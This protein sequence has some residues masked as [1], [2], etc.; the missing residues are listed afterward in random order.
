MLPA[1]NKDLNKELIDGYTN[2]RKLWTVTPVKGHL[3]SSGS[4]ISITSQPLWELLNPRL[5]IRLTF[6]NCSICNCLPNQNQ[7]HM[8]FNLETIKLEPA[9][10]PSFLINA[11]YD[12]IKQFMSIY[13]T[14]AISQIKKVTELD[15]LIGTLR[16]EVQQS[17]QAYKAEALL[18]K[19]TQDERLQEIAE[20]A[21]FTMVHLGALKQ[22]KTIGINE[23][24]KRIEMIFSEFSDFMVQ[25]VTDEMANT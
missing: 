3:H 4:R 16:P 6:P 7:P 18:I 12:A 19:L 20:K 24:K 11:T 21:H 13:K 2:T 22:S 5:H 1:I 25:A 9:P 23:H 15:V 8:S 17:Y 14:P 10:K